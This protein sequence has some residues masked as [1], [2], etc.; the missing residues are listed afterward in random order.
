MHRPLDFL[1]P[2][3]AA[4]GETVCSAWRLVSIRVAP[5]SAA[6]HAPACC[7]G[8][9][10]LVRAGRRAARVARAYPLPRGQT[11][12][13]LPR[14]AARTSN[15]RPLLM[16]W[17]RCGA[18]RARPQRG[19]WRCGARS[20]ARMFCTWRERLPKTSLIDCGRRIQGRDRYACRGSKATVT[21]RGHP[22]FTGVV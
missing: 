18:A 20:S 12:R 21:S 7:R 16:I 11:L 13:T 10:R 19:G 8:S 2:K 22:S 15:Q 9:L 1:P 4:E 17:M 5:T 6:P 14:R 3:V